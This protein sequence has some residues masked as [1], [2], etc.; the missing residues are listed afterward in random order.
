MLKLHLSPPTPAQH[1]VRVLFGLL[2]GFICLWAERALPEW[3]LP[4]DIIMKSQRAECEPQVARELFDTEVRA[5]KRL[6][7]LQGKTVPI[8]YGQV[9]HDGAQALL[10]Q[11][12]GGVSLAE[13]AGATLDLDTLSRLLQECYS[14][15]HALGVHHDDPQLGNF[16]LVDGGSR[17]I[18]VDLEMVAFDR[19]AEENAFFLKTSILQLASRYQ[20]MRAG[21]RREG[22]LVAA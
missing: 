3:F 18:A 6:T 4:T 9:R 14:A 19:S 13:P 21:F 17:I 16:R 15:L 12:V 20:E 5:Y 2:R 10:L 11:D 7:P 8:C 22:L 1:F